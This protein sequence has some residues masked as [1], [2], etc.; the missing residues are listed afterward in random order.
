[1]GFLEGVL[2]FLWRGLR[3]CMSG[4][5]GENAVLPDGLDQLPPREVLFAVIGTVLSRA[6]V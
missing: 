6:D 3:V 5:I 2:G 4:C 1:M